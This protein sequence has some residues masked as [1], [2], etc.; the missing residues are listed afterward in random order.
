MKKSSTREFVAALPVLGEFSQALPRSAYVAV[1][2]DWLIVVSD[3]VQSRQAISE[4]KYKAVNMA[5]VAMISAI[6]NRLGHQELPYIFGGDGAAIALSP[7]DGEAAKDALAR[8]VGWV[9]DELGLELRAAIVP[10]ST[11]RSQS[12]DVLVAALSVS[13]AIR[14]YAFTGGGIAVA[15]QLMKDGFHTIERALPG[16]M[17]DLTGLSCR[18]TPIGEP[19]RHIVSMIIEPPQG[20]EEIDLE[21][22]NAL[23]KLIEGELGPAKPMPDRGPGFKWPPAGIDLESR[24]TGMSRPFLYLVTLIA[25]V[26]DRTG[27]RLGG[28]DPTHYREMTALNTDYRKIQ[29]GLR[30][31]VSLTEEELKRLE[32]YLEKEREDGHL[33]FGLSVQDSAVL[34]CFV[35]SIME[36][37][38]FHFLD[39]AGGGYAAAATNLR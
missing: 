32:Q 11:L 6:M 26:L 28:F 27:I 4:G 7:E 5:G 33:R 38:H 29:D 23:L 39:G 24:A 1:P 15:E 12:K 3:I 13:E 19:D 17:P 8:T 20:Q 21:V 22:G 18:W 16:E 31:T 9:S 36:D 10:V 25:F 37:N 30:M 35:P 14:N 34:T 2:D